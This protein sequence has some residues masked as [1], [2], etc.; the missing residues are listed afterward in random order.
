MSRNDSVIKAFKIIEYLAE[1]TNGAALKSIS[2]DLNIDSATAYR[3][4]SSLRDLGYV[5]QNQKNLN[6]QLTTKFTWI[7][8]L[9]LDH[10]QIR[11]LAHH[12]LEELASIANETVHLCVLDGTEITYI[13]KIDSN[14]PVK[15]RSGIGR[16]GRVHSTGVGKVML[17]F[18]PEKERENL[19]PKLNLSSLTPNTIT[20]PIKL[21]LELD[22]IRQRGYSIDDQE[23]EVGIRCVGAPIF[24]HNGYVI[25]AISITG[26][27]ITMTTDRL[28][29]LSAT[30]LKTS[31]DISA[32]LGYR[33]G[34]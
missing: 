31:L 28:V 27:T 7:A 26:W 29:D 32:E 14:Q 20:D 6:Y 16:R 10:I 21:C 33:V 1:E 25:A 11:A 17:A 23:D 5:Q 4:L 8:S 2:K 22:R 3:Y 34:H 24:D 9:V 12:K 15:M 13:D 18:L 19:L 30:L